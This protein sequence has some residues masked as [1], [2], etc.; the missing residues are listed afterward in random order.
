ML[1][2]TLGWN[3]GSKVRPLVVYVSLT[4]LQEIHGTEI[5]RTSQTSCTCWDLMKS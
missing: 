3:V 1:A 4:R 5:V 2:I